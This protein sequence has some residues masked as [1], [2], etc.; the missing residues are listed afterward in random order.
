MGR[1]IIDS[2][3]DLVKFVNKSGTCYVFRR[4]GGLRI[5][6]FVGGNDSTVIRGRT[7]E[8]CEEAHLGG[9]MLLTADNK[10]SLLALSIKTVDEVYPHRRALE[11]TEDEKRLLA[12]IDRPL[13]TP[14]LRIVSGFS[15][16]R[17]DRS[18]MGLRFKMKISLMGIK[19]ESKTKHLNCFDTF[20]SWK[21]TAKKGQTLK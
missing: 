16:A 13:S 5:C 11:L 6:D 19:R 14:E 10:G 20:E 4:G 1:R 15:K 18:L 7:M 8:L 17:F 12:A 21:K 3:D 2:I 9:R